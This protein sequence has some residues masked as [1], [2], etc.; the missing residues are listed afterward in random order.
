MPQPSLHPF[1]LQS[2]P[3]SSRK[4]HRQST[5]GPSASGGWTTGER[6]WSIVCIRHGTDHADLQL[7]VASQS[8]RSALNS[9][10]MS[11]G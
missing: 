10:A 3:Y 4:H 8:G 2:Q 11:P 9:I 5:I 6:Y 1:V 7:P